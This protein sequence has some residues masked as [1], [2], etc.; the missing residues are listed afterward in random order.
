MSLEKHNNLQIG[1]KISTEIVSFNIKVIANI[2]I[3]R[4]Q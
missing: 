4:K 3:N 2:K 1:Q